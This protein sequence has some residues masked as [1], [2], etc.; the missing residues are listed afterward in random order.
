MKVEKTRFERNWTTFVNPAF[1]PDWKSPLKMVVWI[2]PRG[3]RPQGCCF[4]LPQFWKVEKTRFERNWT[5]FVNPAFCP[6][7][8]RALKMVVWNRPRGVRSQ[9]CFFVSPQWGKSKKRVLNAIG[10]R[11]S[12]RLFALLG[13]AHSKWWYETDLVAFDPKGV[14]SFRPDGESRKTRFERNWTT[15]VNPA[16]CPAWKS[17]LKMVVWNRPRGIRSQ[18]CCLVSPRWGK[19][20]NAFWTQ[21]DDVR[22]PGFLPCLEKPTQNGGMKPTSWYSILRVFFR[23]A[24]MGKV[25]KTR[26]ERNWTTFVNPAF[27]PAW[28]S[29]LKMVVWNRRGIRSQGYCFV[30]PRWG[31]SKN[32]FWT[33]LED[34]RQPGFLPCFEKP[35][36]N[37]GLKPTS[38]SSIPRVFF[39]FAPMGKVEK[40]RFER[41]WTTFVN[42]AFFPAWKS[43]LKMVVWNRAGGIRSQ[44]CF[45]VSPRLGKS[46]KRVMNAIG[47]RS[48]T[49][50]FALLG[51][52]HSK[53][54]YETD[55]VEFD[56]KG[57]FSFRPNFGKSK[58]R[59]LN[60][61]G[62]RS[63]TRLFALLGK[64]HSK[65]WYETDLVYSI[66]RVFFRFAPMGKVEKTRFERNWTTFVNPAF[67]PAWKSPLK[68]MVWNRPSGIRS[69]GCCFVSPRWEKSKK[70]VLNANGRRSWTRLFALLGKAHSKW[71]YETDLVEFYPKG[72]VSF[73]LD[74]KSRKNA[75]WSE[76]DDVRQPGFLPCL[77]KPTQN[78]GMKPTSWNSIPRVFFRFARMGKVEKTRFERN[79]TTFV[80]PAFCP[81]WKSPLKIVVWNRPSGIRSQGC[82]FVS[83]R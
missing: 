11:S 54:S 10:R 75:F 59:V 60:A 81:A 58:K 27:C 32:A 62:R 34:V 80:N 6:A 16:F 15:F 33:Q 40:T 21:L 79:W 52:A 45:F 49:R 44:G 74:G 7:W 28:K 36:Q 72:V 63:S 50:L 4:V 12:T 8:K 13:K 71:W 51:K 41:N 30:S 5:T 47:R 55:L 18:G 61:I 23:F 53:W 83:P 66:L 3:I 57:V 64:A 39:R 14:V 78:G 68:M 65:W 70:R 56:P 38:W 20:K 2:R 37:G 17:P 25:E 43:P 9:V 1:C 29:P 73:R 26:F 46:K 35:T 69:Q 24:P 76:M 42:P 82:C 31:K 77:E 67:C 22:Q 19:S 48:W